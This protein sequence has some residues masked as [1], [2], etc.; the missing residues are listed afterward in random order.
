MADRQ[1]PP[2][3]V[4]RKIG[5]GYSCGSVDRGVVEGFKPVHPLSREATLLGLQSFKF[6]KIG[7]L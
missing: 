5:G 7:M 1:A 4:R 6:N 2:S 3:H